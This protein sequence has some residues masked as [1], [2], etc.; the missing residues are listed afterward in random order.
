MVYSL[1]RIVPRPGQEEHT[2]RAM[3]SLADSVRA[4]PGCAASS[5]LREVNAP[6]AIVYAEVWRDQ[7]HL[8]QHMISP[9]FDLMLGL[10][11]SSAELPNV[12]FSFVSETRGL[13]WVEELRA[14]RRS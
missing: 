6:W 10:V 12:E 2:L 14:R 9:D 7:E 8:E 3:Q 1:I 13:A 5:I 4:L 11:E